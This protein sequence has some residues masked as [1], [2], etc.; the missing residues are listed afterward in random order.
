VL[1]LHKRS[2]DLRNNLILEKFEIKKTSQGFR[3]KEIFQ[4]PYY[5]NTLSEHNSETQQNHGRRRATLILL[6]LLA[7]HVDFKLSSAALVLFYTGI[8]NQVNPPLSVK[9][10]RTQK[11]ALKFLNQSNSSPNRANNSK[12]SY[13]LSCYLELPQGGP[14][15]LAKLYTL[16]GLTISG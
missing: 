12:G 5:R 15:L 6:K 14:F 7:R 9:R 13:C 10:H 2:N 3:L 11:G 16:K 4:K 1:W 8:E